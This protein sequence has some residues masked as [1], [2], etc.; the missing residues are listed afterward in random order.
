[1]APHSPTGHNSSTSSSRLD[2]SQS[3]DDIDGAAGVATGNTLQFTVKKRNMGSMEIIDDESKNESTIIIRGGNG[4]GSDAP[5]LVHRTVLPNNDRR[6]NPKNFKGLLSDKGLWDLARMIGSEW[7]RLGTLLEI[8]T[9]VQ[10][11]IRMDY[12]NKTHQQI[13]EML[14]LWRDTARGSKESIKGKLHTALVTCDRQ[15]L[16]EDLLLEQ[17]EGSAEKVAYHSII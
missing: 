3:M 5:G 11:Q 6:N 4:R 9:P 8:P 13:Y 7:P 14:R 2:K 12:P 10:D 16:A 17:V 1:M 15:D